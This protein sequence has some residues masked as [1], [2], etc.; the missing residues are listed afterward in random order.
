[1]L[2]DDVLGLLLQ[3]SD[4]SKLTREQYERSVTR[5][6]KYL[7]RPAKIADLSLD[8]ANGFL[9][10]A[11]SKYE[12]GPVSVKNHR[13]GII[14]VWNYCVDPLELC[15][16]FN[17]RRIKTPKI[18]EK[19]VKAWSPEQFELLLSSAQDMP[20]QLQCGVPAS[21][22]LTCWLWLGYDT[23]LRPGD[24]L[25]LTW[26]DVDTH[27]KTITTVQNKNGKIHTALLSN[28]SLAALDTMRRFGFSTVF[29]VGPSGV[30]RWERILFRRAAKRGFHRLHR[31][32]L[33]TLRKTHATQVFLASDVATAA[34]SLGHS[35]TRTVRKHYID[36]TAI[37][38]GHLPQSRRDAGGGRDSKRA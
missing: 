30:H 34:E 10:W 19:I 17:P 33:G 8:N 15:E 38:R 20:G 23:G 1:M 7:E 3:E 22:F 36:S 29:P 11:S 26:G 24:L 31:Q 28:N 14:R 13:A 2:L 25:S 27:A 4:L 21:L 18:P 32:G 37:C 12:L 9:R 35:D 6:G 5:F 16:D